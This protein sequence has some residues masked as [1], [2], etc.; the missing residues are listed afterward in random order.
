MAKRKYRE[1]VAEEAESWLDDLATPEEETLEAAEETS[2]QEATDEP[3]ETI[4][5]AEETGEQQRERKQVPLHELQAERRKRQ[6]MEQKLA[7][8][9]QRMAKYERLW[10]KLESLEKKEEPEEEVPDYEYDP[11]GHLKAKLEKTEEKIQQTEAEI[12][13]QQQM[14]QLQQAIQ[15]AEAAFVAEHPDYY[16]ALNYVRDMQKKALL[17]IAEK[18]GWDDA[19]IMQELAMREIQGAAVLL[20]QNINPSEYVYEVAKQYGFKPAER[21]QKDVDADLEAMEKKLAASKTAGG[22]GGSKKITREMVDEMS[23]PEFEAAMQE[24]FGTRH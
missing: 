3:E 13:Q 14:A 10:E 6:E 5:A 23:I 20:Q 12:R 11:T 15:T 19:R 7:E 1:E 22:S 17:P 9:E 18:Q 2:E 4:E 16:E 8:Y 24:M 21:G